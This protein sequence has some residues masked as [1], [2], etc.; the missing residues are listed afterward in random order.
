MM[1]TQEFYI[2]ISHSGDHQVKKAIQFIYFGNY[3]YGYI[4]G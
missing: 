3:V 4:Y 2:S 1:M